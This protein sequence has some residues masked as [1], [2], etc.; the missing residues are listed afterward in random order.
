MYDYVNGR[1]LIL[2]IEASYGIDNLEIPDIVYR[3]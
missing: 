3:S 2:Y 1:L